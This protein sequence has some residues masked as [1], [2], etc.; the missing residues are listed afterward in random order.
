M[1]MRVLLK[2]WG[3]FGAEYF[4]SWGSVVIYLHKTFFS[5][6]VDNVKFLVEKNHRYL[7]IRGSLLSQYQHSLL[8]TSEVVYFAMFIARHV[9]AVAEYHK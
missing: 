9:K 3:K 5:N 1:R 7:K 8:F 2:C 4:I 6:C